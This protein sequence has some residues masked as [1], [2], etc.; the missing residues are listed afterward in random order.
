[1]I[2]TN[3]DAERENGTPSNQ[4]VQAVRDAGTNTQVD[5]VGSL[6]RAVGN[7]AVRSFVES[8]R[9][10]GSTGSIGD[11]WGGVVAS[12]SGRSAVGSALEPNVAVNDP[13]DRYEREAD[14]VAERV[15][16]MR[17][18]ASVAIRERGPPEGVQ[19][20]CERCRERYS[21]G[22]PLDCPECEATLQRTEESAGASG[23]AGGVD[24]QI[25]FRYGGGSPLSTQVRSYF[26][27]RMG[28]DFSDVRVHTG[29]R[30]EQA[31]QAVYARAFT[32]GR[33]IFFS[34]GEYR[35]QVESGRRLL[36]H[37]LTH[38]VQQD[39]TGNQ[40]IQRQ[41]RED[42]E[43]PRRIVL[44]ANSF[45]PHTEVSDPRPPPIGGNCFKGDNRGFKADTSASSRTH[46]YLELEYPS[47]DTDTD[48]RTGRTHEIECNHPSLVLNS[49]SAPEDGLQIGD[50]V[51]RDDGRIRVDFEASAS[52]PLVSGSPNIDLAM[53]AVIDPSLPSIA[54]VGQHDG[55][56]AYEVYGRVDTGP[57]MALYQFDPRDSDQTLQSL[58]PPMEWHFNEVEAL[59]EP[60]RYRG[61]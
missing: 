1:M 4:Q 32:L 7:Q 15:T 49:D 10:D 25:R 19:R 40:R 33:D 30:A 58:W 47:L 51:V 8:G 16:R 45:I 48:T 57:P 23:T 5:A 50:P 27:S 24:P 14:R 2:R 22:E 43:E 37:E 13:N 12:Q 60:M 46:Q 53:M 9:L 29:P 55:F 56:P 18:P 52:N 54:V 3:V 26:E 38:V 17:N 44:W 41:E 35:P 31:T 36:A 21:R 28:Y 42:D 34:E 20:L 6:Q 39:A 11:R 59:P 61:Q